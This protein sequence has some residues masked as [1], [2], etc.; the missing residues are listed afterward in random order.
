[1]TKGRGENVR[2]LNQTSMLKMKVLIVYAHPEKKAFPSEVLESFAA[3]LEASGHS[4]EIID[5]YQDGFD[6]ATTRSEVYGETIPD[7]IADY[8]HM[9]ASADGLAFIAPTWW[10]GFPAILRGWIDRVLSYG[11]AYTASDNPLGTKG[12]LQHKKVTVIQFLPENEAAK[13][14][15]GVTQSI[16]QINSANFTDICG[17]PIME[18]HFFD[19]GKSISEEERTLALET[20]FLLGKDFDKDL[21]W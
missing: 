8:Q 19:S 21:T 13:K 11:F 6:P 3:G 17:I 7:E 4:I 20:A 5:L 9:V 18:Q 16:K 1:M 10:N 14:S 15:S 2:I 12:L